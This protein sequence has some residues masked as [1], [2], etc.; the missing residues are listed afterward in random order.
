MFKFLSKIVGN[1]IRCVSKLFTRK[2]SGV[3]IYK[4][5]AVTPGGMRSW[6]DSNI[7][8]IKKPNSSIPDHLLAK[9]GGYNRYRY[10]RFILNK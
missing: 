9:A 1:F 8:I 2:S 5:L 10:L 4:V 6:V 3:V 7:G